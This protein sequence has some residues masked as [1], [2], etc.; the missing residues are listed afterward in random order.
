M[1]EPVPAS[2][3]DYLI[4]TASNGRQAAAY[5][6][7]LALRRRLGLL[8]DTASVLVVPD[9]Q[10]KRVGSGGSTVWCLLEVL[11]GELARTGQAPSADSNA[12]RAM[13]AD[14]RIL[15]VHAGGDSKRTPAYGP[16]GKILIPVPGPRPAAGVP[17]TLCD[18]QLPIYFALPAPPTGRGQVV[19]V[20]GDDIKLFDPSDIRW[21]AEGF[22]ALAC[23]VEPELTSR[24]GGFCVEGDG[25]ARRFF[26]K[27][28]VAEQ[29]EMGAID[30]TGRS[31]LDMAV[32][33]FSPAAA[34][35]L[36]AMCKVAPGGA[37][38]TWTADMAD[39]IL[40]GGLDFFSDVC[41]ALGTETT[42]EDYLANVRSV[43][44]AW[45]DDQ[46]RRMFAALSP[47]PLHVQTLEQCRFLH[48]GTTRQLIDSG[49][50]LLRMDS[51][52]EATEAVLD[53]NNRRVD[54]GRILG[55]DVL[56]EGCLLAAE[57]TLAGDNVVTG[58]DVLAP[59][60]LPRGACLD[61]LRGASRGGED[62]WFVRCYGSADTNKH[63]AAEG[64]TFCNLP[65]ADWLAAAGAEACEV[66][67]EG[68]P[69]DEQTV[70]SA[71]LT[72][73]VG[74]HQE[75]T[76]WLWMFDPAAATPEQKRT[77]HDADRYSLAEMALLADQ[78]AFHARRSRLVA[79]DD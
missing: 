58:V 13:L 46:L 33:S 14:L 18:R 59:L 69:G 12:W 3:W 23:P 50:E 20:A 21:A 6:Q 38:L 17:K 45:R 71:R 72:P 77:W 67:P 30:P 39:G 41:C 74:D 62:V 28:S 29:R 60:A 65:L 22:T 36:L 44:G 61:V 24:H 53:V 47:Q 70:W 27:A 76:R 40:A 2:A 11:N 55:D 68:T 66:W 16:C 56:V 54:A 5:E 15:I 52:N 35:A 26:Q 4:V 31:L 7:Q 51:P 75:Y 73:A 37:G 78:D 42:F 34:A 25:S 43:G 9:P 1:S 48:F 57:L 32:F 63:S 8:A 79:E 49:R 10:G 19:I 64:G